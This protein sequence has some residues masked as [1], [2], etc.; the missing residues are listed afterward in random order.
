MSKNVVYFTNLKTVK[1]NEFELL[2]NE[3]FHKMSRLIISDS[4]CYS[5]NYDKNYDCYTI[6]YDGELYEVKSG[7]EKISSKFDNQQILYYLNQLVELSEFQKKLQNE[8]IDLKNQVEKRKERLL[9]QAKK[10]MFGT[11]EVNEAELER[12]IEQDR[13]YGT[14]I[15]ADSLETISDMNVGDP[16]DMELW[17]GPT[18]ILGVIVLIIT[19]IL[20][21]CGEAIPAI[22]F[23][24]AG[25]CTLDLGIY[26]LTSV[27]DI[28]YRGLWATIGSII[29]AP[30]IFIGKTALKVYEKITL[31]SKKREILKRISE[32]KSINVPKVKNNIKDR[33][34]NVVDEVLKPSNKKSSNKSLNNIMLS[35]KEFDDI[36]NNIL[37]IK[38]N[39]VKKELANE[40][41]GILESCMKATN[42]SMKEKT[43]EILTGYISN[44]QTKVDYALKQEQEIDNQTTTY[45]KLMSEIK[46]SK[47]EVKSSEEVI[48]QKSIGVR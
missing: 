38:D 46:E 29:A 26:F 37:L 3:F 17:R 31:F 41:Y 42:S 10:G 1:S 16:D 47:E 23:Y 5:V 48:K 24:I 7:K 4:N 39:K 18:G 35:F 25:F 43:F 9:E 45:Y 8:E 14:K 28:D 13:V 44:L 2:Q 27:K 22:L 12:I 11:V 20:S 19:V 15:I 21:L 32:L 36:K 40:L 6:V 30:F 34:P 33:N